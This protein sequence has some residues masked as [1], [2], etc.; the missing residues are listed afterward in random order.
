MDKIFKNLVPKMPLTPPQG[1]DVNPLLMPLKAA[2]T[3][4][5]TSTHSR[6]WICHLH[7]QFHKE[8]SITI[9]P[10]TT[11]ALPTTISVVPANL[12]KRQVAMMCT[13]PRVMC[14]R[15]WQIKA[16]WLA[17][18]EQAF[19]LRDASIELSSPTCG[20]AYH[21]DPHVVLTRLELEELKCKNTPL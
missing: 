16:M 1:F 2:L 17:K 15:S 18:M 9:T 13:A 10:S 12:P 4:A 21:L 5:T 19:G 3:T 20:H 11:T 8:A 14:P 6:H 7:L